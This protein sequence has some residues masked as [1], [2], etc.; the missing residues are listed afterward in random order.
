MKRN[1]IIQAGIILLLLALVAACAQVPLA[2]PAAEGPAEEDVAAPPEEAVPID[3]ESEMM[4]YSEFYAANPELMAA[5]RY[6]A[7]VPDEPL[8]DSELYAANPE[9]MT[10][11]RFVAVIAE[12]VSDS[13][14]YAENPELMTAGRY[15]TTSEAENLESI[16]TRR[17]TILF[18]DGPTLIR[19]N[20]ESTVE[21]DSETMTASEF[22]A[23]NPELMMV[24]RFV[25]VIEAKPDS[26]STLY[27]AN[28]ELMAAGRYAA[29]VPDEPLSASEFYAANPELC[30][31]HRYIDAY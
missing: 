21:R 31:A 12:P 3:V 7:A 6:S 17:Y 2:Q 20:P 15:A 1:S 22:Y 30:V 4:T 27:A 14:L 29:A 23:A 11:R 28:P 16:Q 5:E 26:D 10:V 13:T 19:V 24:R 18:E 9:L 8:S 25:A